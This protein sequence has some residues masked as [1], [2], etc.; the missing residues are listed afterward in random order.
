MS[1]FS[2]ILTESSCVC[3]YPCQLFMG[4]NGFLEGH[5]CVWMM[6]HPKG[7]NLINHFF[8]CSVSK[9]IHIQRHW[10]LT[11]QLL[12]FSGNRTHPITGSLYFKHI[13]SRSAM[14]RGNDAMER[15]CLRVNVSEYQ[16]SPLSVYSCASQFFS[17]LS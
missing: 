7:L 12:N 17:I 4:P 13:K 5:Q 8:Q 1:A 3:A 11:L 16:I 14:L 10:G 6:P 15:F 9:S 2:Y